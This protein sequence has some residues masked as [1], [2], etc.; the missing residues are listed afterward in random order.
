MRH[1]GPR[2]EAAANCHASV[3]HPWRDH[4]DGG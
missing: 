3:I 1:V 2:M 4:H